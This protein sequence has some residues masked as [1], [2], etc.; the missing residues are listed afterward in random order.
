VTLRGTDLRVAIVA[1]DEHKSLQVLFDE[2]LIVQKVSHHG[3]YRLDL[4]DRVGRSKKAAPKQER[5]ISKAE[6]PAKCV[7]S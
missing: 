1:R 4:L 2:A 6:R 7:E 3:P 5:L